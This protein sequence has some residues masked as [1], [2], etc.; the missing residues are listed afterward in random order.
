MH[1]PLEHK[2]LGFVV[3]KLYYYHHTDYSI[4]QLNASV[5]YSTTVLLY[6]LCDLCLPRWAL[7]T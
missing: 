1:S 5:V 7:W 2:A 6:L 3:V 4:M